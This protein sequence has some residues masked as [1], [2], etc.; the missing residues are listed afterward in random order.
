M[1]FSLLGT[2][3]AKAENQT[4][5]A[6]AAENQKEETHEVKQKTQEA[7]NKPKLQVSHVSRR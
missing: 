6:S 1:G 3:L 7:A 5:G 4:V 2:S